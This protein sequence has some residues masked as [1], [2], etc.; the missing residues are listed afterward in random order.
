[1]E[2]AGCM[3]LIRQL[4][5][6]KWLNSGVEPHLRTS[7]PTAVKKKTCFN[8][9]KSPPPPPPPRS[10]ATPATQKHTTQPAQATPAPWP[11]FALSTTG[12]LKAITVIAVFEAWNKGLLFP[13]SFH[14]PSFCCVTCRTWAA[15]APLD[16]A[17]V[18]QEVAG[19]RHLPAIWS[20]ALYIIV[21]LLENDRNN[22]GQGRSKTNKAIQVGFGP[23]F[24][25]RTAWLVILKLLWL[26]IS[27]FPRQIR[28]RNLQTAAPKFSGWG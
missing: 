17:C 4:I 25:G 1:M 27:S 9:P 6:F 20:S 16:E 5:R 23:E 14:P 7:F 21:T 13:T 3:Y 15:S 10:A 11:L 18:D 2:T 12:R 26:S 19:T 28:H 22:A 24:T 8:I